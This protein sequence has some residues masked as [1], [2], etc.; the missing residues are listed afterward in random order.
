MK[1]TDVQRAAIEQA[2]KEKKL[3]E[4]EGIRGA[5]GDAFNAE[6]LA[7]AIAKVETDSLTD[8]MVVQARRYAGLV[9]IDTTTQASIGTA[10]VRKYEDAVGIGRPHS[11]TGGDIP[12][13]EVS[14]GQQSITVGGGAINYRYSIF[15]MQAASRDGINLKG[16][17]ATAARLGYEKH[18]Y[19]VAMVG[20]PETGNK[21]LLNHDLPEVATAA[22]S[23][24]TADIDAIMTDISNA[25]GLAFDEAEMTGDTSMLPDTILLPSVLYRLLLNKRVSPTSE[26]TL[27]AYITANNLLTAAGVPNVKIEQLYELNTAGTGKTPRI[28]VYRRDPSA[29]E[30][31]LPQDLTFIA[32]Q[33]K[34]LDI[35]TNGYYLYAG[36]WIKSAKSIVYL[37]GAGA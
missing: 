24:L 6:N 21:G 3:N 26:T 11:G 17:K 15:E 1:F 32:P 16:A 13:A 33:A 5:I 34:D 25:I 23:W 28:V 19:K 37:D 29:L 7:S 30:L 9:P 36:L 10:L 22:A 35:V 14:Y 27:L 4:F 18:M 31:I 12:S 2:I 20:E 8:K